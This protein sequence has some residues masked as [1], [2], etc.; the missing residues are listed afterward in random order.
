V[1]SAPVADG[2]AARKAATRDAIADALLDLLAEGHLRPTAREIAARAGIS[3]RSIYVHFDDLE[4]LLCVAARR[5]FA[6][7]APMLEPTPNVGSTR[8]RVEGL[9]QRRVNLYA[10]MGAI[11]RATQLQAPFSPTLERIVRD[12]RAHSK[13]EIERLFAPEL[14]ALEPTRRAHAAAIVEVLVSSSAW[15]ALRDVHEF[16][17]RDA[18]SAVVDTILR[19]LAA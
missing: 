5:H 15:E 17:V 14:D 2:R 8:A 19:E 12:A 11:G 7:M 4:D 3:L 13:K 6:R 1:T 9:V 16:D 10:N 18:M